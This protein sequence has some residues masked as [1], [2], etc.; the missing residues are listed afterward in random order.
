MKADVF[1]LVAVYVDCDLGLRLA[2]GGLYVGLNNVILC[3][4]G[5]ALSELSAPVG[6]QLPLRLLVESP[7]DGDGNTRFRM[8]TRSPDRAVDQRVILLGCRCFS[9]FRGLSRH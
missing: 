1:P 6:N 3:P 7:A 2:L 8:I 4:N 5:N 9:R